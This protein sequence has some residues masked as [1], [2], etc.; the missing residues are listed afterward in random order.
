PA[1]QSRL[2]KDRDR[3]PAIGESAPWIVRTALCVEAR[4]G[5]LHIFMPPMNLIEDYLDLIAAIEDTASHLNTRWSSKATRRRSIT[6][7]IG[8]R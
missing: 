2:E 4:D 7:S 5:R 6:A 1:L 3:K 8:S